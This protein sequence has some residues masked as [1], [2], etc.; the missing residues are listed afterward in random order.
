MRSGR[1]RFAAPA[2]TLALALTLVWALAGLGCR[3]PQKSV[4][5]E[6]LPELDLSGA[7]T[8]ARE[9]M[10]DQRAAVDRLLS[11]RD[12]DPAEQ[13]EA[14]GDLGLIYVTYEFLEAA[15]VCFANALQL[16]PDDFR[17][18][19]LLGYLK[20]I[21]G[22]LPEADELYQRTLEIEPGFLPAVL[23]LGRGELGQGRHSEA[24]VWFERALELD[25]QAAAAHEG[26]GK[27]AS[28]EGDDAAA[29]GH[30]QRAL[31]LAPEASG[32][33]YALAQSHRNLGQMD[34]ARAHLEQSGDVAARVVDPLINPLASM[35]TSAQFYIVQGAEAM[36][37]SDYAA[38][39]AAFRAALDQDP[40]SIVAARGLSIGLERLGDIP[41]AAAALEEVLE[42]ATGEEKA[43]LLSNLGG[44]AALAGDEAAALE[45][46]LESL[47]IV[48]DQ[49]H[50]LLRAG[51]SLARRARFE[52][53]IAQYDRL[54]EVTPEWAPAVLE[55]RA[56]VLVNLRRPD[57][58]IA[59]FERALEAAPDD[60][61]LRMRYAAALE[62]LGRPEEASKQRAAA[63]R[64]TGDE[65]GRLAWAVESAMRQ[66]R[67][68]DSEGA[69]ATL[70]QALAGNEGRIELRYTL[71]ALLA[72]S[73]RFEEAIGEFEQVLT[74][75]PRHADARRGQI[76]AMILSGRFGEAR[77]KLQDALRNFPRH[78]GF[79]LTQV[80]LLA[81]S[82]DPRV[83]DGSLAV[84]IAERVYAE[85]RDPPVRQALALAHAANGSFAEAVELQRQLVRE[86]EGSGDAAFLA[87]N[88]SRL[89]AFEKGSAWVAGSPGEILAALAPGGV[90]AVAREEAE[91]G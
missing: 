7:E 73:G 57:E 60:H 6:P 55:K 11:A 52:E 59:D 32:I 41:G 81:L 79:A 33:H 74:A 89:E 80:R 87:A 34:Q 84:A 71:A 5:L 18:H 24:R 67:E 26:L 91:E 8:A 86:A 21:Q 46:Y 75:A 50:L 56:T 88:R 72:Q 65:E 12:A 13:A 31:E 1:L 42:A 83:R 43:V 19:Y 36:D 47:S 9:Q 27:V 61:Q 38:S 25:P 17:W 63:G 53:A 54:I 39:S 90:T 44:L 62:F 40:Q 49:P 16:A 10:L 15:E 22:F 23:R 4:P 51:N 14:L 48:P 78:Q 70:R 29:V 45:R 64:L 82:P 76:V 20:M 35:A 77:L 85:R 3:A 68:G 69:V 2:L 66:A 37:D 28:A 30:F 58:A